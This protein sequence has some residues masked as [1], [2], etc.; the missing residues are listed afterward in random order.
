[1]GHVSFR[2][3]DAIMQ[4][5]VVWTWRLRAGLATY[6]RVADLGELPAG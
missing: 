1:M 4:R 6:A 5:S 3:D 2:R